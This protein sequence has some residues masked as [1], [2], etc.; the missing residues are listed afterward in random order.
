MAT[1]G[2]ER[3]AIQAFFEQFR[4]IY[5]FFAL[6]M[7]PRTKKSLAKVVGPCLFDILTKFGGCK[8]SYGVTVK[9]ERLKNCCTV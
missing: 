8:M 7:A 9:S 4:Y 1:G 2:C 6:K 5:L 3:C